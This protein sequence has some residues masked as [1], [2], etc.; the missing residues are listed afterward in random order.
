MFGWYPERVN[1]AWARIQVRGDEMQFGFPQSFRQIGKFT[2]G[3]VCFFS[4][5]VPIKVL[6]EVPL[7]VAE[8]LK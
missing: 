5:R 3:L 2:I 8:F 6:E 4:M 7:V 1:F